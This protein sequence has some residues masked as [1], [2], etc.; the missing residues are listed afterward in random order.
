MDFTKFINIIPNKPFDKENLQS[1]V[2]SQYTE[3]FDISQIT[4]HLNNR[5]SKY[6]KK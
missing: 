5:G 6:G 3:Y 1:V 2:S 4:E